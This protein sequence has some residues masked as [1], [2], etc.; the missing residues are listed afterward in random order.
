MNAPR[1]SAE[2]LKW[3]GTDQNVSVAPSLKVLPGPV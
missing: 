3:N 1:E 2:R